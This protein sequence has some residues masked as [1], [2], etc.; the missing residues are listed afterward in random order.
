MFSKDLRKNCSRAIEWYIKTSH[1][2]Y[3]SILNQLKLTKWR[4]RRKAASVCSSA[5]WS[6]ELAAMCR[7]PGAALWRTDQPIHRHPFSSDYGRWGFP[8]S[9]SHRR[10]APERP[11]CRVRHQPPS[12]VPGGTVSSSV[13]YLFHEVATSAQLW[14]NFHLDTDVPHTRRR[15]RTWRSPTPNRSSAGSAA[16][17]D[18]SK[19]EKK[20]FQSRLPHRNFTPNF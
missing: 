8:P 15:R 3:F 1:L 2:N 9:A 19:F 12:C 16:D 10:T 13:R 6:F 14:P 17:G 18:F 5:L 7:V 20:K 11:T 4:F